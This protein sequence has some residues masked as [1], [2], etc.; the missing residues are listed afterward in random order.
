SS[1]FPSAAEPPATASPTDLR[2][3]TTIHTQSENDSPDKTH[4]DPEPSIPS[5][6]AEPRSS[7]PIETP[8]SHTKSSSYDNPRSSKPPTATQ[9][10]QAS[11][12]SSASKHT[13][14]AVMTVVVNGE[15]SLSSHTTVVDDNAP[16]D[17]GAESE[18]DKTSDIAEGVPYT[19]TIIED[20]SAVVVTGLHAGE[21]ASS[22]A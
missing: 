5:P 6:E 8:E 17:S 22:D 19:S 16:T 1:A 21:S 4:R 10:H 3:E 12:A 20:G 15:T 9:T 13:V 18:N 14:V 11:R 7:T 2:P